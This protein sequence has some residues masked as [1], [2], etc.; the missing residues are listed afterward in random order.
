MLHGLDFA[1]DNTRAGFA[2]PTD[3]LARKDSV[4]EKRKEILV[5]YKG[6]PGTTITYTNEER[7]L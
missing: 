7:N 5:S 3:L 2:N 6:Q 4:H 1:T